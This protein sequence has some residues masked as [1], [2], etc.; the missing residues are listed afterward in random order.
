MIRSDV[1]LPWPQERA[2]LIFLCLLIAFQGWNLGG[3]QFWAQLLNGLLLCACVA[4]LCIP[5]TRAGAEKK[6]IPL[7][8][9]RKHPVF[10]VGVVYFFYLFYQL[11][12]PALVVADASGFEP[13]LKPRDTLLPGPTSVAAQ[14]HEYT[15]WRYWWIEVSVWAALCCSLCGLSR[16]KSTQVIKWTL[17][18]NGTLV[19]FVGVLQQV[20]NS[21]TILWQVHS[22][23][24]SFFAT[25]IYGNHAAIYFYLALCAGGALLVHH[26]R[27]A[28]TRGPA[29]FIG[30][31][32]LVVCL[33]IIM[34]YSRGGWIMGGIALL[35]VGL[36]C[37]FIC[38]KYRHWLALLGIVFYCGLLFYATKQVMDHKRF[39]VNW[40]SLTRVMENSEREARSYANQA[41]IDMFDKRPLFGWGV[42]SFEYV[43]PRFQKAYPQ[44]TRHYSSNANRDVYLHWQYAHN[45]WLQ[46][47][48]EKGI[49]GTLLFLSVGCAFLAPLLPHIRHLTLG[50]ILSFLPA[51]LIA[52]HMAIDYVVSA[53]GLSIVLAILV[54]LAHVQLHAVRSRKFKQLKA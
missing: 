3:Y 32:M 27:S 19:A 18:L 12:N 16:Y 14:S 33:G 23:N 7:F 13:D 30:M 29:P 15:G 41:T 47:L 17:L 6:R 1:A 8:R 46:M 31:C 22:S 28:P 51:L 36:G 45:D 52:G 9:L 37:L 49:V 21:P 11:I 10:W 48:A 2:L 20:T 40:S 39:D 42:G 4:I 50:T 24:P 38:I 5:I 25:F 43:F 26:L 34:V 54:S 44:I 53:Q 35:A